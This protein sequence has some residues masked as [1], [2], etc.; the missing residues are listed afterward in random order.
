[1]NY[2]KCINHAVSTYG[3]GCVEIQDYE[4]EKKGADLAPFRVL[5]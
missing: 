2:L 4:T 5:F 1:M 3:D